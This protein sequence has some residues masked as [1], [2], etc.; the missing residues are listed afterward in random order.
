MIFTYFND[1]FFKQVF[2]IFHFKFNEMHKSFSKKNE[3]LFTLNV[4]ITFLQH[5]FY[6]QY[7]Q[8]YIHVVSY[9]IVTNQLLYIRVCLGLFTFATGKRPYG[10]AFSVIQC[11][12]LLFKTQQSF[13]AFHASDQFIPK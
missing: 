5:T 10:R 9:C 2:Q 3:L 6:I 13:V 8:S 11:N 12:H 1:T 7:L 4:N